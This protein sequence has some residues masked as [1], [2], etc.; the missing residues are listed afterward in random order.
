M[1]FAVNGCTHRSRP[2]TLLYVQAS[3]AKEAEV[4]GLHQI[5]ARK[6]FYGEVSDVEIVPMSEEDVIKALN[7]VRFP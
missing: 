2:F 5:E 4:I 1:I 3:S 7:D 6:Q